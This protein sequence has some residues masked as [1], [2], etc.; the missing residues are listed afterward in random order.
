MNLKSFITWIY[1]KGIN[2]NLFMLKEDEYND[3]VE[4]PPNPHLIVKYQKYKTWLYILLFTVCFY[5]LFYINL[6]KTSSTTVVI[7]NITLPT[8]IKLYHKHYQTL[9]CPCS[10][11]T[12]PY[13]NVTANN[14]TTHPIC[15]SVFISREW[16]TKLYFENA[17]EYGVWDFR[18]TAYSQFELLSRFC[19]LSKQIISQIL[20]DVNNTELV[21]LYLLSEKQI[22][23]EIYGTIEHLKNSAT[24]RMITFFDYLKNTTDRHY[25][26]TAL[27]TNFIILAIDEA[28]KYLSL[29]GY[30]SQSL[31]N[32]LSLWNDDSMF[33]VNATLSSLPS[34]PD[35]LRKRYEL[36]LKSVSMV[37]DGF[38]IGYTPLYALL[39]STLDCLY[40]VQCL[41]L[42]LDYFPKLTQLNFNL[43]NSALSSQNERIPVDQYLSNLFITNWSRHIDYEKY[44]QLCSPS[45]CSYSKTEQTELVYA[46]TI[47]ISLYGGLIIVLRLI[48]SF[49]V[50]TITKWKCWSKNRNDN[51]TEQRAKKWKLIETMRQLNLFKDINDRTELGIRQQKIVT[52]VYL[53]LLFG[54]ICTI[55]LFTSLNTEVMMMI[56]KHPTITMYYFLQ[57]SFAD[58]FQ[59]PC[60]KKAI[61]YGS[62]LSLSPRFHQICS[63]GFIHDSW[64][65]VLDGYATDFPLNDWRYRLHLQF[66]FLSDFCYLSNKTIGDAIG[67][68]LSQLFLVSFAMNETEL[69]KQ[70]N[71]SL[72]QFYRS[73][74]YSF[75]VMTDVLQLRLQM[76]QLYIEPAREDIGTSSDVNLMIDVLTED[77][78]AN[79]QMKFYFRLNELQEIN[80]TMTKCICAIDPYCQAPA[81]AYEYFF[82]QGTVPDK[83]PFHYVP[84]WIRRCLAVDSLLLSSLE[85]LYENSACF[86]SLLVIFSEW[87]KY[88]PD[89]VPMIYDPTTT[90]FSQ[91]ENISTIFREMMI[92]QWYSSISYASFYDACA[93]TYC[94]YSQRMHTKNF[95]GVI[96][97]LLSMIG[98][99]T[100]SLR[101]FTPNLI[102]MVIRL[103]AMIRKGR[104]Q[105]SQRGI[106]IKSSFQRF[107]FMPF[108]YR[109]V[110]Q[111][112]FIRMKVIIY[113]DIKLLSTKLFNLNIF[114]SS[115]F[116]S[117]VD[118]LTTKNYGRWATRLYVILFLSSFIVLTLYTIFQSRTVTTTFT[119][120]LFDTYEILQEIHGNQLKC[121][122]SQIASTYNA[123]VEIAPV[124]H[125]ICSS[126]FVQKEWH[127]QIIDGLTLN[128]STYS[129]NDYRR[130]LSAHLQYLQVLC[131]ISRDSVN[132]AINELLTSLLVTTE[133]LSQQ[134]FHHRI[135]I[136]IKQSE[137]NAPILLSRFL[138]IVQSVVHGNAFMTTYQTN[139]QYFTL[140]HN[141]AEIFLF[142]EAMVYDDNCSC[143]LSPNCTTQANFIE[144]DSSERIELIGLKIGCLPSESF[145]L[146]TL[147]CFHNQS[148][149]DLLHQYTN[150]PNI[151]VPR[152]IT[153][154]RFLPNT[155]VDELIDHAFT[156]QWKTQRNYSQYYHR[157]SPLSCSYSYT[158]KFNIFYI[159][160]LFLSLQGGLTLVLG[161]ICPKLIQIALK[162]YEYYRRRH[163]TSVHPVHSPS[164]TSDHLDCTADLQTSNRTTISRTQYYSKLIFAAITLMLLMIVIVI[165]S[166]YYARKAVVVMNKTTGRNEST[167]TITST[168]MTVSSTTTNSLCQNK[169]RLVSTNI[170]CLYHTVH[171]LTVTSGDLNNDKRMDLI[172]SCG[173]DENETVVVSL[174]NGNGTFSDSMIFVLPRSHRVKSINIAD[175]NNDDRS[176]ILLVMGI[177]D[178]QG[179]LMVLLGNG[180]GTFQNL[181]MLSFGDIGRITHVNIA[182]LNND[183][184]FDVLLALCLNET[185]VLAI[186]FGYGNGTFQTQSVVSS[187]ASV[188]SVSEV[189]L[190]DINKNNM[191]D[192][193]VHYAL[194]KNVHILF[195][196]NNGSFSSAFSLMK[197]GLISM[198]LCISDNNNDGYLDIILYSPESLHIHVFLGSA[199]GIFEMQTPLF[200]SFLPTIKYVIT[201]DFDSDNQSDIAV[202]YNGEDL[203]YIIYNYFNDSFRRKEKINVKLLGKMDKF[204]MSDINNDN[205]VDIVIDIYPSHAIDVLFG[206]GNNQFSAQRVNSNERRSRD[207]FGVID[208]NNDNYKDIVSISRLSRLIDVLL[209]KHECSIF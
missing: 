41:Q 101:I 32:E 171:Q 96:I 43:N 122:C 130:F 208:V 159:I 146:S 16:V 121:L 23:R 79:Q 70:I 205:H 106:V 14:I 4:H 31:F 17:S 44:F 82:T 195:G 125:P 22:E 108:L 142:T 175:F 64:I 103:L 33:L 162:M 169:F 172:Y 46:I 153:S 193:V 29:E 113:N 143:G 34:E 131:Q 111:S 180:N 144:N 178:I 47:F 117:N 94:T 3:D 65:N 177:N 152:C 61:S 184:R 86:P 157:C 11:I 99:M 52:R 120:P 107:L 155:T 164:T 10:T 12:I 66:Q 95:L 71:I 63:S 8:Y 19:S 13:Q 83:A 119:Q 6:I 1:N 74:V 40:K 21:N 92:E 90:R 202:F 85:C 147:E 133:L 60:S 58:S 91:Q 59:C 73:T 27:N 154:N 62:F 54:S 116:G 2:Y 89:L 39:H 128:F 80:S 173:S 5:I 50:D 201:G 140:F 68:Y 118:R 145:H 181:T 67:R 207:W 127:M 170:S 123:F 196:Q 156:E 78:D 199:N 45:S 166:V 20:I 72:N 36:Y 198:P 88:P 137:S 7:S 93:P 134:D 190:I 194:L 182:D 112:F 9:I 138:F 48:V 151:T 126:K 186:V 132:N 30:E 187:I 165:F 192:I 161:W 148:C 183:N 18:T 57:S 129:F 185:A 25:V 191:L 158:E 98:G 141:A 203:E 42:L 28:N 139:F 188:G 84:G 69:N 197:N 149:V 124:F 26:I 109:L 77:I 53:T 114:V 168:I 75:A 97:T 115:E 102:K 76:D 160:A 15:S 110:H 81:V 105:R 35:D 38:L 51:P 87:N 104:R 55:C 204:L 136:T 200:T 135:N 206:Y 56:E 100:V 24:S 176:D 37:V 189:I 167:T 174:S 150:Y 209:N 163:M 49:S 179:K